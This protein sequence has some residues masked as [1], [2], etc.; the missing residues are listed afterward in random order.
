MALSK[1]RDRERQ[2][3]KIASNQTLFDELKQDGSLLRC[4][5]IPQSDAYECVIHNREHRYWVPWRLVNRWLYDK[6]VKLASGTNDVIYG[7]LL[8]H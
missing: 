5:H 1:L 2:K 3:A 7:T 4:K 8:E 6:K